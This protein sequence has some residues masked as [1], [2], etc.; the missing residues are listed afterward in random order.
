MVCFHTRAQGLENCLGAL[1]EGSRLVEPQ[2]LMGHVCFLLPP[3]LGV[4]GPSAEAAPPT[5][6]LTPFCLSL[7]SLGSSLAPPTWGP[8]FCLLSSWAHLDNDSHLPAAHASVHCPIVPVATALSEMVQQCSSPAGNFD[9]LPI[10]RS[11]ETQQASVTGHQ[12][13]AGVTGLCFRSR[14]RKEKAP[15]CCLLGCS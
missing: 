4:E 11:F 15:L 9:I 12:W 6:P 8:C 5:L 1:G 14:V 7:A 3:G 13:M 2:L 10:N